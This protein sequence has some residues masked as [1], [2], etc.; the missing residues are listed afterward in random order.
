MRTSDIQRMIDSGR[1]ILWQP[2]PRRHSLRASGEI[3]PGGWG[4]DI[5]EA[6]MDLVQAWC[7]EHNCGLRLSFDTFQFRDPHEITLFLLRWS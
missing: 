2:G 6:D 3:Q 4:A 7:D 1:R 5:S